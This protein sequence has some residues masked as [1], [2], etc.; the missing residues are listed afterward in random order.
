MEKVKTLFKFAV[1]GAGLV[2][3]G[4]CLVPAILFSK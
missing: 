2:V 4:I 3:I 1:V